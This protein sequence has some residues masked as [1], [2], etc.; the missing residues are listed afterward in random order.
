MGANLQGA[1]I[2]DPLA[3][4][5]GTGPT[6]VTAA[7]S[8]PALLSRSVTV[9]YQRP[10]LAA[11]GLNR[12]A[13]TL[14]AIELS[15]LLLSIALYPLL[16][17][18][19]VWQSAWR[20]VGVPAALMLLWSYLAWEPGR[21][22]WDWAVAERILAL[23][24]FCIVMM[25]QP[26]LQYVGLALNR[27]LID[28]W[29]VATDSLMGV[30]LVEWTAWTR[31]H[32]PLLVTLVV[33]YTSFGMQLCVPLVAL[34]I[35]SL[36]D[37]A[38][39]W[40]Y[41]FHLTACVTFTMLVFAFF[42]SNSS[43]TLYDFEPVIGQHAVVRHIAEFRS[44]H[45]TRVDVKTIEG[46]I[47]FPS[48]HVAGALIVTWTFR[49]RRWM[50]WPLAVLNAL[51]VAATLLLGIH[52]AIDIV[53]GVAVFMASVWVYRKAG[54]AGS[55]QASASEGFASRAHHHIDPSR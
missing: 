18:S 53:A 25:I 23:S 49:H 32:R 28:D 19:Y 45:M 27:P 29:L 42:P 55:I 2:R 37:R 50:M 44:G 12:V 54:F 34:G 10:P 40:E 17:L 4:R 20:V 14:L 36:K 1:D 24:V 6:S 22:P 48:F 16:G 13:I 38:A 5:T 51:L 7:R 41:L 31:Q 39:L 8:N 43:S 9:A 47:S 26:Q 33:A 3:Q 15:L 52:Y 30:R 46:L 21:S 35:R 11:L